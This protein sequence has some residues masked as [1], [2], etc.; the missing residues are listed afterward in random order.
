[1]ATC[2][3]CHGLGQVIRGT[4][5]PCLACGAPGPCPHRSDSVYQTC[6]SCNGSGRSKSGPD[7]KR[8]RP[9]VR[10][11]FHDLRAELGAG[12]VI[13][14]VRRTCRSPKALAAVLSLKASADDAA[15]SVRFWVDGSFDRP[16]YL[17]AIRI[18]WRDVGILNHELFEEHG[19]N[20]EE[21]PSDLFPVW[22]RYICA[23][24]AMAV[25]AGIS[26]ELRTDV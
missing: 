3:R 22:D 25:W 5:S 19:S 4:W 6:P 15:F 11:E 21:W 13:Y 23:V 20:E 24:A 12:S 17:D 26:R 10:E 16:T 9:V 8:S 1:M 18:L 14:A 2:S 7:V